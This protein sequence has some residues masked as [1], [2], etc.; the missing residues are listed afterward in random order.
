[1][2]IGEVARKSGLPAPTIR[3]YERQRL[4]TRPARSSAGYRLYA[5]RV[6]DELQFIRRAQNIGLTLDETREILA[7]G[8][9]GRKPC[10]RVQTMCA[11]HL[12]EIERKIAELQTLKTQLQNV[13]RLAGQSCGFTPEGFC[14]AIFVKQ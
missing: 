3:F 8:R 7:L 2:L 12:D 14:R 6:L 4:V 9:A 10:E 5:D 11:T 1:M 13:R